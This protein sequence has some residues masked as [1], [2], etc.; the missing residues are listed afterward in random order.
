MSYHRELDQTTDEYEVNVDNC[1]LENS[2]NEGDGSTAGNFSV[3]LAKRLD[4]T[5]LIYLRSSDAEMNLSSVQLNGLPLSFTRSE[6]CAVKLD[7]P[8]SI[9]SCNQLFDELR[10]SSFNEDVLRI[11]S[12]DHVCPSPADV[13]AYMNNFT[14]FQ[15]NHFI[16]SRYL[17]VFLD[18]NV[19]PDLSKAPFSAA[20]IRVLLHYVDS[21]LYTRKLLHVKLSSYL[22]ANDRTAPPAIVYSVQKALL[23]RTQEAAILKESDCIIPIANRMVGTKAKIVDFS[24]FHGLAIH[25]E[26]D[27]TSEEEAAVKH[28]TDIAAL[29]NTL[30]TNIQNWLIDMKFNLQKPKPSDKTDIKAYVTANKSLIKIGLLARQL[31]FLEKERDT[32]APKRKMLLFHADFL[33]YSLDVSGQRCVFKTQPDT[34]LCKDCSLRVFLPKKISFCTTRN[35]QKSGDFG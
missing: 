30:H 11:P 25:V 32:E 27:P 34:Y 12:T 7:L 29:N 17:R 14:G 31:L 16:I 33:N 19:L 3:V 6:S 20:D 9:G 23:S 24:H 8:E 1:S 22:D 15:I 5:S 18:A 28:R 21:A 4:L 35:C 26:P 13:I 2:L 10:I